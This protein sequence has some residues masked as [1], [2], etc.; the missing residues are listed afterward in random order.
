MKKLLLAALIAISFQSFAQIELKKAERLMDSYA[1]TE[2]AELYSIYFEKGKRVSSETYLKAADAN[3]F[4]SNMREA[5]TYFKKANTDEN[6]LDAIHIF[7]YV[8][9]LRSVRD[10]EVANS[11]FQDFLQ[12]K[13]DSDALTDFNNRVAAFDTILKSDKPSRFS[14]TNL[15][16]N[17]EYSDFV[18]TISGEEV[19][20]SSSRPGAAKELYAWN[21]QPYLS[22]FSAKSS[23]TG[24]LEDPKL[25]AQ[26]VS[27]NFHDATIAMV[28]N[29]DVVYFTSSAIKKNR[30]VLDDGQNNNFSIY[31]GKIVDGKIT[32][33]ES[34]Y[35][36][37]ADYSTG[38]PS[39]SDDGKYL[40]FASD[41]PGGF[42]EADIYISEIFEDGKLSTPKNAGPEINTSGN[43]FF[44]NLIGNEFYFS[45][46]GQLGYGGIDLF[47]SEFSEA[48]FTTPVNLGKVA[49]SSYDDF[50]IVFN[51]DGN[52][53]Y[54]ASNREGG[55]G[56]DDIYYF[57]RT[58]LA[59]NQFVS[60]TTIDKHSREKLQDVM[61]TVRDTSNT[62][63]QTIK[64]SI[65]GTYELK[66]P[67]NTTIAITAEKEKYI[68]KTHTITTGEEDSVAIPNVDFELIRI[69]DIIVIDETGVEKIKLDR[70]YFDYDKWD[71]L[72]SSASVLDKAV[73]VMNEIPSMT[74]KIESHTDARGR[75]SYNLTLS[76]KRAEA[77]RE[78]LYSKGISENRIESALG[79]GESRLLNQCADKISCTDA[80]HDVNRRSD[81]IILKR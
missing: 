23:E 71:I 32:E 39:V 30:L 73:D 2:A 69:E 47:V 1:Y 9:S 13:G 48:K 44:P 75:D 58:P 3:Y 18:N 60:G 79:Y 34:V 55:K 53:G 42:G 27:S 50:A 33:K 16:V 6:E 22:Q 40:F 46:N 51:K 67:C 81:F 66:I 5:S 57:I 7:R 70:I 54:F 26:K 31:K 28:P 37:S 8:S 76:T 77:T 61:I 24:E 68:E 12:K 21:E 59:C 43:D 41:M 25:F 35:F 80:D 11:I 52:S 49:N 56:D 74:I 45:S 15:I 38:H 36:S 20:F 17:T 72:S 4:I 62:I 65:D 14:L 78:Y 10:Y 19:I 63:L 64:T 29:S